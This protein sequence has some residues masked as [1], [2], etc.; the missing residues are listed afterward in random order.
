VPSF[1]GPCLFPPP[2]G[3]HSDL[4][5]GKLRGPAMWT[6]GLPATEGQREPQ[7]LRIDIFGKSES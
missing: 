6:G 4:M 1:H 3:E 5:E 7:P 2:T